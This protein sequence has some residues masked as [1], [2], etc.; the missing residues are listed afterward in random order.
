MPEIG[1]A[2]P[3][4][5]PAAFD[6]AYRRLPGATARLHA[7]HALQLLD[8]GV[9]A[10]AGVW[11]ARQ[12]GTVVGVQVAVPLGGANFLFWLPETA[13]PEP[14]EPLENAL[15]DAALAWCGRGGGKLAQAIV[16]AEDADRIRPLLRRGFARVTRL[17]YLSHDLHALPPPA[18]HE[19]RFE[20]IT[21]ANESAF[22]ATLARTYEG[23]LDCPELN[24][25]RTMDEVLAGYRAAA[26]AGPPRWW[27]A[28]R[29]GEP[30]G[31]LILTALPEG[32]ALDLSYVGVVPEQRRRGV[33]RAAT[34]LA[35]DAARHAGASELLVAVDE[36]NGPARRLYAAA[37]FTDV[38][39]REVY[40]HFFAAAAS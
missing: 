10:P 25:V 31:V 28:R 21:P 37:G 38:E 12:G 9:L 36:R 19:I 35:L 3:D 22:R 32:P 16:P 20:P 4:E 5:W 23:T 8:A 33:A 13:G 6:L 7:I 29:A 1:P 2:R 11:V 30:A 40:L 18:E 26:S 27:L 14:D 15:V 17:R 34:R 39:A 24:G